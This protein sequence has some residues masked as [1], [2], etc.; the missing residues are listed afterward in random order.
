M[1]LS[2]LVKSKK[3]LLAAHRGA[4][5]GNIP[6]NTLQA[7]QVALNHG[8]D[9][10][11]LDVERS[12]DGV[13]F[14]QHPGMEWVHLGLGESIKNHTAD[15][16]AWM[17]R[18]NCDMAP[19]EWT[20]V[21]LEDALRFL[22]GKCIVNIDKFW[23]NPQSIAKMVRKLGMQDQVLIKTG[24]QPEHID[25][26]ERYAPELPYMPLVCGEDRIHEELMERNINYVGAEVIFTTDDAPVASPEY[27]DMMHRNGKIV[28][29][30]AIVY[31]YQAVLCAGHTDDISVIEDPEKGW[32][33]IADRGF[34]IIQT[35]WL[36][37]CR[38][39]LE[40]TGRRRA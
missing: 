18:L 34:D 19:T 36:Y 23:E 29:C 21:R 1:N 37:P 15:E 31:A 25:A 40:S 22:N 6:C 24:T 14:V 17:P 38:Q 2:E 13:L 32:G 5:A 8:A 12:S 28:W 10:V 9:I 7:F 20:I 16:V 4:A 26:V 3:V 27:L 35:D 11:E 33:W 30:N 39:F